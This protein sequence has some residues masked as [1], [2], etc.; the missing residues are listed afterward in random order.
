MKVTLGQRVNQW[1]ERAGASH[2]VRYSVLTQAWL[3]LIGPVTILVIARQLEPTAQ[4]FYYTFSSLLG[5]QVVFELGLAT[6]IVQ[7]ASHEW[8]HLHREPEGRIGGADRALSRLASLGRFSVGWYAIAAVLFVGLLLAGGH[9]YFS[10]KASEHTGLWQNPWML[11]TVVMGLQLLIQPLFSLIE[12]CNQVGSLYGIRLVQA[13]AASLGIIGALAA[14]WGLYALVLGAG[15]RLL[16]GVWWLSFRQRDFCLLVLTYRSS[17][18]I[19]WQRD[20]WPFQWRIAISWL[21]GY[22]VFSLITPVMFHFHGPVLAGQMGMSLVIV[23]AIESV[24]CA[25]LNTR[26]PQFGILVAQGN[27]RV[28]DE[29]FRRALQTS[30]GLAALGALGAWAGVLLLQ[31]FHPDYAARLLPLL[32]LGLLIVYRVTNISLT[33]M[34]LY[35]RAHKREP[36][37]GVSLVNA[38]LVG[39]VLSTC[40]R[41]YGPTGAIA[42]SLVVTLVWTLPAGYRVFRRCRAEWHHTI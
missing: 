29:M 39:L 28:L 11:L 37:M 22:I 33:G 13:I 30:L 25:W 31:G 3:A 9:F 2:A 40:G 35:L 42:G 20:I 12:G 19:D 21:S 5:L 15:L 7:T 1:L 41:A 23:G 14:G 34:A 38:L 26:S 24:A 18:G 8:A 36:L 10:A 32:P 6:V 4:G 17:T 27:Y 16:I